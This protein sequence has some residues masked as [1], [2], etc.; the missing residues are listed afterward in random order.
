MG[1]GGGLLLYPRNGRRGYIVNG[2]KGCGLN[3][4]RVD[5]NPLNIILRDITSLDERINIRSTFHSTLACGLPL[6]LLSV[7]FLYAMTSTLRGRRLT[8]Q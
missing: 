5:Y 8:R 2:L 7:F 4:F 6:P 3:D 1:L